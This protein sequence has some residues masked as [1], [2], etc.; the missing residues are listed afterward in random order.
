MC[1]FDGGGGGCD[2]GCAG[3]VGDL[4][5]KDGDSAG[6]LDDDGLAGQ[7]RFKGV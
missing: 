4:E 6:S 1:E 5:G 7:E 2:D 3:G